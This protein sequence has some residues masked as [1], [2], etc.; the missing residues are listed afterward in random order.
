MDI[1]KR[2]EEARLKAEEEARAAAEKAE[3]ERKKAEEARK[4]A[5]AEAKEKAEK[6][7]AAKEKAKKAAKKTAKYGICIAIVACIGYFGVKAIE[8]SNTYKA[9]VASMKAKNYT[10]AIYDFEALGDYK[11]SKEQLKEATYQLAKKRMAQ[12]NYSEAAKEFGK[13]KDYKDSN[14]LGAYCNGRVS[15][16]ESVSKAYSYYKDLPDDLLDVAERKA[17]MAKYKDYEG[18]YGGLRYTVEIFI[19]N[20][21]P[22]GRWDGYSYSEGE[23][24]PSDIDWYDYYWEEKNTTYSPDRYYLVKGRVNRCDKFYDSY[25]GWKLYSQYTR[26]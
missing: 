24:K 12:N 15:E 13:I 1:E 3:E 19:R 14:T 23:L 5:E 2:L 9:A 7:A 11:D 22:H 17:L 25:S 18:G 8:R 21:I 16:A 10:A 20:G 26:Q 6:L 4:K